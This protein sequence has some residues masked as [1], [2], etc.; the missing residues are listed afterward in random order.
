MAVIIPAIN[1]NNNMNVIEIDKIF[2]LTI[3]ETEFLISLFNFQDIIMFAMG[4]SFLESTIS[5]F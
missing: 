3:F 4:G 5:T 2:E 1:V